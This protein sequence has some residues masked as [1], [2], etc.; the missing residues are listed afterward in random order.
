MSEEKKKYEYMYPVEELDKIIEQ[1]ESGIAPMLTDEMQLEIKMRYQ[2]LQNE[3]MEDP[4]DEDSVISVEDVKKH[5]EMMKKHLE[6]KKREA[7]KHDIAII[8]LTEK[9]RKKLEE[10]MTYSLVRKDPNDPY[11]KADDEMYESAEKAAVIRRLSNVH[12]C[13][14]NQTDYVNAIK[15][16]RD[17]IDYSLK[18]DYP[19][20]SRSQALEAFNRGEINFTFCQMPK[21]YING[22][23]QITDPAI[24]KGVITG[25]VKL[26]DRP[27]A[28]NTRNRDIN[29]NAK[30]V[31]VPYNVISNEAYKEMSELHARGYDTPLSVAFK[32][33]A[34]IYNRF[35]LP[36]GNRFNVVTSQSNMSPAEKARQEMLTNFDWT[37]EG[38]GEAYFRLKY[39]RPYGISDIV[40]DLQSANGNHIVNNIGTNMYEFMRSMNNGDGQR[41]YESTNTISNTMN[42]NPEAIQIEQGILNAIRM[43]N[44]DR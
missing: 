1:I 33:K 38:A 24:L 25:E 26:V 30:P 41:H 17:A 12:H 20:M 9:Q 31:N 8:K 44:P 10:D 35:A 5:Q 42:P 21:L 6:K 40:D 19:W 16:I 7:T 37:Q 43:N 27:T 3:I 18:T 28:P 36:V 32:S 4:D 2:E 22:T 11:N 15:I 13:Y 14:F 23:K 29:K 39:N 34:S